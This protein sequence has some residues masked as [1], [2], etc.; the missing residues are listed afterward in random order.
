MPEQQAKLDVTTD[1]PDWACLVCGT[2]GQWKDAL[3]AELRVARCP[4]CKEDGMLIS[5]Q[6]V[7]DL[8]EYFTLRPGMRERINRQRKELG[9]PMLKLKKDR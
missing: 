6:E 4:K 8:D 1:A 5:V 3:W 2:E 7:Q 9:L